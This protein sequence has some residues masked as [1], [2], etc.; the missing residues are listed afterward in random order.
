MDSTIGHSILSGALHMFYT[1]NSFDI[2][3][4]VPLSIPRILVALAAA[5]SHCKDGVR[6]DVVHNPKSFSELTSH[7]SILIRTWREFPFCMM[8][9]GI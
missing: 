5:L 3:E 2:N 7:R 6:D 9:L 4:N 1:E 8:N